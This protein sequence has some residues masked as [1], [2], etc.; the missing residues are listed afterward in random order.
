MPIHLIDISEEYPELNN[1]YHLGYYIP[2]NTGMDDQLSREVLN[3]KENKASSVRQWKHLFDSVDLPRKHGF[4]VRVLGHDEMNVP[5]G[6]NLP[7]DRLG[8]Y[9]SDKYA[10]LNYFPQMIAKSK[11]TQALKFLGRNER[12][13]ELA[14]AY[15]CIIFEQQFLDRFPEKRYHKFSLIIIDDII[16]TGSSLI[17]VSHAIQETYPNA[18]INCVTLTKTSDPD[19]HELNHN[20]ELY[21]FFTGG[22]Q[23]SSFPPTGWKD[24][25]E[26]F[27]DPDDYDVDDSDYDDDAS[28][29]SE[30]STES[31]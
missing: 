16:T 12:R 4:C 26:L 27:Q 28:K 8:Q 13:Q 23:Q 17:A 21:N 1:V 7:L 14:G 25:S 31:G 18:I 22:S 19:P 24:V 30:N 9:L 3:F 11:Q 20:Q 10:S 29:W 2:K 5:T 15:R 6:S